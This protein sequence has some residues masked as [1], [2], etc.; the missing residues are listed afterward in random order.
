VGRGFVFPVDTSPC[1]VLI[2][3]NVTTVPTWRSK[4][5]RVIYLPLNFSL[6]SDVGGALIEQTFRARMQF[7][8]AMIL[9]QRWPDIV[10][11]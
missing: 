11:T 7:V 2:S 6:R 5:V 1:R 3:H 10:I 9:L 8:A 4:D